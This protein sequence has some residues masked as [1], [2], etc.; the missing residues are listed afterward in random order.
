MILHLITNFTEPN[1]AEKML[2]RILG[3]SGDEPSLV[4]SLKDISLRNKK[5]VANKN[6][7]YQALGMHTAMAVPQAVMKLRQIIRQEQP[8][9][10]L[11]WMYHAMAMG[12]IACRLSRTPTPVFWNVRQ[13][14]DDL[15]SMSR[16]S[17]L[18]VRACKHLSAMPKG[19]IYNSRRARSLHQN[20][21]YRDKNSVVIPNG[22][23]VPDVT[24]KPIE[25]VRR[26]GIAGRFHPQK[27]FETFFRAAAK[28]AENH[29]DCRFIAVGK[30][31]VNDNDEL[32]GLLQTVELPA[33]RVELRGPVDDMAAFYNDIDVL[34]L[35][36]RTEGFPNVVAEAMS[37]SNPVIATDVGDA[38]AIV[39][40]CGI[41]VQPQNAEQLANAMEK[42][43]E[44]SP[45]DYTAMAVQARER[46][47]KQYSIAAVAEKYDNF[48]SSS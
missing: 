39:E 10:I 40:G 48:F 42:M 12:S 43:T 17:R 11:C 29:P 7:R 38:A 31:L 37:Y 4:V 13:S 5:L 36:S 3:Y 16:S 18:S 9:L 1:G 35:S 25:T 6:V 34:V 2:A 47:K 20:L 45:A 32:A 8:K 46:I 19:I 24:A 41:V 14:L 28:V 22:F 27:D 21:G 23:D 44:L 15:T 26:F 30:G 33:D